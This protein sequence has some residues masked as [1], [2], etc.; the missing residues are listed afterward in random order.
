MIESV[1]GVRTITAV[2][3]DSLL[4]AYS[5]SFGCVDLLALARSDDNF[6]LLDEAVIMGSLAS[7]VE[8]EATSANLCPFP[9]PVWNGSKCV[10]LSCDDVKPLCNEDSRAGVQ[11]RFMCGKTCGCD[12]PVSP[13]FYMNGCSKACSDRLVINLNNTQCADVRPNSTASAAL[14]AFAT[15]TGMTFWT[16]EKLPPAKAWTELGCKAAEASQ[17]CAVGDAF[18]LGISSFVPFCPETCTCSVE[19]DECPGGCTK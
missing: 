15:S 7:E 5:N 14:A 19:P 8:K 13:L 4:S 16:A 2:S 9:R 11:T 10:R 6:W 3:L 12:S 18:G 1:L 17:F